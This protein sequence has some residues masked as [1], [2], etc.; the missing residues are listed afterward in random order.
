MLLSKYVITQQDRNKL[1]MLNWN[2][3]SG[4]DKYTEEECIIQGFIMCTLW[5]IL[6]GW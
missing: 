1:K 3:N 2:N 5:Q 4:F 6:L